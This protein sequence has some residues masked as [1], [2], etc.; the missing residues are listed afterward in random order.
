MRA[1]VGP[2]ALLVLC[3]FAAPAEPIT[4]FLAGDSTMA[5][6][7]IDRRP[8]H[9][10][11]EMLQQYFDMDR[12]RVENHAR[13]GR[14]TRTFID[15]GRWQALVARMQAG[16]YVFIQFGHNDSSADRPDRYTPPADYRRNLI[17]MVGDA[18]AK[19]AHPVLLTPVVRRR[20]DEH[21]KFYYSHGEYPDI[22]REVAVEQRVPL[23]D[24]HTLSEQVVKRHGVEGSK[25]LFLHLRAGEHA[26]YPAGLDDNTHFSQLGADAMAAIAAQG[27]RAAQLGIAEFLLRR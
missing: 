8:E 7:A 5:H 14:S 17:R 12:V 23:I 16:D 21:G 4:L 19:G 18:R 3:A 13:N 24:M 26:N 27:I 15:E 22:V 9:G 1:L 20:F 2:A 10:W 25:A 6:K 11:G